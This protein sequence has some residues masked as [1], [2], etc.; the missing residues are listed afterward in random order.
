M[1]TGSDAGAAWFSPWRVIFDSFASKTRP[2]HR[3]VGLGRCYHVGMDAAGARVLAERISNARP[4]DSEPA[5]VE[6]GRTVRLGSLRR[7]RARARVAEWIDVNRTAT[8]PAD[9]PEDP[10]VWIGEAP[11][12]QPVERW[13]FHERTRDVVV[14]GR[15]TRV[16]ETVCT[17]VRAA[18]RETT[19]VARRAPG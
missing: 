7:K 1:V 6:R 17:K 16:V 2:K 12:P 13:F 14:D 4:L 19:V 5:P 11:S 8:A 9:V 18:Q 15:P 10:S 3:A